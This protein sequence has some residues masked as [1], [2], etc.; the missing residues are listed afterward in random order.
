MPRFAP[1][2]LA[3]LCAGLALALFSQISANKELRAQLA[4][5]REQLATQKADTDARIAKVQEQ[6]EIFKGESE[7]LRQKLAERTNTATDSA[8]PHTAGNSDK[9]GTENA[10][11]G[12]PEGNWMKGLAKMFT[13]PEMKKSMRA[14]QAF[15]IRL[16]YSDLAK[17]LGLSPEDANLVF[18]L[19]ADRQ[20]DISS[21]ALG[22]DGDV[23]KADG[24]D[25][26]K[27]KTGYDAEIKN[28]LGEERMKKFEDYE[29][30]VGERM[31]LQQY[32]QSLSATGTP[33]DETQRKTLLG[34][35]TEERVRQ[36][37]NALDP[38]SKDVA[39]AVK[40]MQHVKAWEA[41]L[42]RQ[43]DMNERV[44]FR[45]KS[46]LSSDQITPFENAQKQMLDMQEMGLKMG[47]AM[48][49][50]GKGK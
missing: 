24:A 22:A 33:L 44:L 41:V 39:G 50:D 26:Q 35:M 27:T 3:A 28:I 48:M 16:M 19:L 4:E 37:P 47:K 5:R 1:F 29:R 43:R 32:Q 12:E 34:I 45:A 8:T 40:A 14:Q 10:A 11:K 30:T 36:P 31:T 21:K 38:G 6:N 49:G 17:E 7:H 15:G 13:D 20:M 42:S 25:V 46:V 9:T 23:T 2:V 18:D